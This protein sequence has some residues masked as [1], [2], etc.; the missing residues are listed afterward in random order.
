MEL[1]V[2]PTPLVNG[3]GGMAEYS[4]QPGGEFKISDNP[5]FQIH[6]CAV[7]N[8]GHKTM[9]SVTIALY[10]VFQEAI[11]DKDHPNSVRSGPITA[12]RPWLISIP[13]IDPGTSNPFVFYIWNVT[14]TWASVSFPRRECGSR[15]TSVIPSDLNFVFRLQMRSL[16]HFLQ[17]QMIQMSL[18]PRNSCAEDIGVHPVVIAEL[19]FRDVER[20]IF[21]AD[22]LWTVPTT[23]RLK[24]LQK[25]SIVFV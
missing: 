12:Q 23:P 9:L 3:G 10:L 11:K 16:F 18:T 19:K 13:K 2:F 24:M 7:T 8:Y 14:D 21:G 4:G 6:K 22:I 5:G 15:S 20:H 1:N 25:P 17:S